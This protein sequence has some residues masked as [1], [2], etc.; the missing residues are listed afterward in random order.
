MKL[1]L[2]LLIG[3]AFM[4]SGE[5]TEDKI[6]SPKPCWRWWN[7]KYYKSGEGYKFIRTCQCEDGEWH[8]TFGRRKTV[9]SGTKPTEED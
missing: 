9:F 7:N 4:V 6:E 8:C 5:S 3:L 1:T 2:L